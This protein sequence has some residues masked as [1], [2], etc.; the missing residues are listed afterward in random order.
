MEGEQKCD[1]ELHEILKS[2]AVNLLKKIHFS[3]LRIRLCND[4][5]NDVTPYIRKTA[6]MLIRFADSS[7]R[8]YGACL[9]V[10][11]CIPGSRPKVEFLCY[12][13]RVV[14]SKVITIPRLEL[15][16]ALL[17]SKL[18]QVV[19]KSYGSRHTFDSVIAF[20]DSTVVLQWIR[21]EP[22]KWRIFIA[23]RISQIQENPPSKHWRHVAGEENPADVLFRWTTLEGL[24]SHNL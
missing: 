14:P 8:A 10:R 13:S 1:R 22:S 6:T 5:T 15:C 20:T 18:M 17:M 23:N 9:Y 19:I 2:N 12:K 16:A 24:F 21:S 11:T 4:M 3:D 7:S